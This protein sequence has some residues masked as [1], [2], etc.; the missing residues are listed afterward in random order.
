MSGTA[1]VVCNFLAIAFLAVPTPWHWSARNTATLLF[2]FWCAVTIIPMALNSA[3]WYHHPH[4]RAPVYCDIVT[5]LRVGGDIGIP[6]SIFCINRQLEAIAA[7]RQAQF[8]GRDRRRQ[9]LIELAIGLGF[10]VLIMILHVVVQ[11][12]RYDIVQGVG[13]IPAYYWSLPLIFII[14]IWPIVFYLA[15]AVYAVLAFRLF[16]ARRFQFARLLE[17]SKSAISTGRFVRLIALSV[18][19]IAYSLPVALYIHISQL[20]NQKLKAYNGWTSVHFDFNYVGVVTF[21]DLRRVSASD[22]ALSQLSY[23]SYAISCALFFIFFGL[24][25]ESVA[26]YKRGFY[27]ALRK[28]GGRRMESSAGKTGTDPVQISLPELSHAES[29]DFGYEHDKHPRID[30]SHFSGV[31]VTVHEDKATV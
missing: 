24:G 1:F 16:V 28:L 3:I 30:A 27:G 2:I 29:S 21:A 23:W 20:R 19:Q 22:E 14:W 15:A 8:S 9:R 4:V 18:F 17:S 6:A 7:A 26:N 13:C 10:P 12:H 25:E 11:G 5:K 31:V